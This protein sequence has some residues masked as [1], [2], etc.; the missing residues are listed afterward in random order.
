M[1]KVDKEKRRK[2][3]RKIE[4]WQGSGLSSKNWCVQNGENYHTFNYWR[5]A[6][7]KEESSPVFEE[8]VEEK[9]QLDIEL[10]WGN[11]KILFPKGC[12]I[13]GFQFCVKA[14][15]DLACLQ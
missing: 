12:T 1:P 7:K 6:L 11:L 2:W 13:E 10:S 15:K 9:L 8:L 3:R 4:K 5:K 14:L